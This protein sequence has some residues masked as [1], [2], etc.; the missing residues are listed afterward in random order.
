MVS[1]GDNSKM[2]ADIPLYI[3]AIICF[4]LAISLH[5]YS[6]MV[7]EVAST[8]T[9][10]LA[11]LGAIFAGVGY[12]MRPK[13]TIE[14]ET[15][16][17]EKPEAREEATAKA[18]AKPSLELIDVKG[19]GP[20]RAEQLKKIGIQSVEDLAKESSEELSKKAKVST[21]IADKWIKAAKE[22]LKEEE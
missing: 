16:T 11:I 7:S 8:Y 19:I 18:E 15:I 13:P 14:T 20:K 6:T 5:L 9:V 10:I 4:A 3:I 21:K 2:R 22:A 12:S 17:I 1:L